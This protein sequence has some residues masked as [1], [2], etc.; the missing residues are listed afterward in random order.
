MNAGVIRQS[1]KPLATFVY[2]LINKSISIIV[3]LSRPL[4]LHALHF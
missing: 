2:K 4:E 3:L 1:Q